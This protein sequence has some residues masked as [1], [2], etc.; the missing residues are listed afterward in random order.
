MDDERQAIQKKTES[1]FGTVA[2]VAAPLQRVIPDK[3]IVDAP[4]MD[5]YQLSPAGMSFPTWAAV[6]K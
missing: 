3:E 2:T 1:G 6:Q 5:L 4:E